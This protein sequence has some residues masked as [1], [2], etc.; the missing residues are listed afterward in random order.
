MRIIGSPQYPHGP[1]EVEALANR[2]LDRAYHPA[3]VKR[4]FMAITGSGNLR[5]VA[6]KITAPTVVIHG[7]NDPLVRPACG[8]AVARAI[9][10]SQLHLIAG[11]GHDLPRALWPRI[12]QL[13]H[14]NARRAG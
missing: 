2:L 7:L 10:H 1:G 12:T 4:Q 6:E 13:L 9:R 3:G 11:M 8:R 14:E 5:P